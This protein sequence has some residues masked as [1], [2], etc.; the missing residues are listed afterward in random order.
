MSSLEI[1]SGDF[2]PGV[3]R[4]RYSPAGRAYLRMTS[5]DG[6]VEDIFIEK[7]LRACFDSTEGRVGDML[8]RWATE[9]G[10]DETPAGR[11]AERLVAIMLKD[12]RR[13]VGRATLDV[14]SEMKSAAKSSEGAASTNSGQTNPAQRG[15]IAG[16]VTRLFPSWN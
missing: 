4:V 14:V 9:T 2:E 10:I 3:V 1:F 6:F 5:R 7:D 12:G 11:R 13:I 15:G 8:K 16:L